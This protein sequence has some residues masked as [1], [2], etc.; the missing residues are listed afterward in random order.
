MYQCLN[1]AKKVV[2]IDTV[3]Y[4]YLQRGSSVM[5]NILDAKRLKLFEIVD[6]WLDEN[7]HDKYLYAA[8]VKRDS[9]LSMVVL[10]A[11]I[12]AGHKEYREMA[13]QRI[14]KHK[15]VIFTSKYFSLKFKC[16]ALVLW[17]CPKMYYKFAK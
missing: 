12:K 10:D 15:R 17:M 5:H 11:A 6:S 4:Y 7:K 2:G 16:G 9:I 3:G 8:V 14:L 1:N 13:R